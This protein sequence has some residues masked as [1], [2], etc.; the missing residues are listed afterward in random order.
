MLD[1]GRRRSSHELSS[2]LETQNESRILN[3]VIAC[4]VSLLHAH[5]VK[6]GQEDKPP[7]Y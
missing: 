2:E 4:F 3:I 1:D 6:R 5:Q 7:V